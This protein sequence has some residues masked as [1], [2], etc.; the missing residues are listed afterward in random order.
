M[1][2]SRGDTDRDAPPAFEPLTAKIIDFGLALFP[3]RPPKPAEGNEAFAA[4]ELLLPSF[5][6]Q[7]ASKDVMLRIAERPLASKP[8]DVYRLGCSLYQV[9]GNW[10]FVDRSMYERIIHRG[11]VS[12]ST[13]D[14]SFIAKVV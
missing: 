9:G 7:A 2:A 8:M 14:E 6:S 10:Y 5:H 12:F 13:F 1:G 3:G 11:K 4:P